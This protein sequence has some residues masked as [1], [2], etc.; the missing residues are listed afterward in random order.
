MKNFDIRERMRRDG[1]FGY[2]V[3]AACGMSE[4]TFSRKLS[5]TELTPDEKAAVLS[6]IENLVNAR[7]E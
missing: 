5:R 2:E 7:R 3:A 4:T 1:V 6:A